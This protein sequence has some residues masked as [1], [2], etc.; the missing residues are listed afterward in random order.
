MRIPA[1]IYSHVPF[2]LNI[3]AIKKGT[4]HMKRNLFFSIRLALIVG[5]GAAVGASA[6]IADQKPDTCSYDP[7]SGNFIENGVESNFGSWE[8][9]RQCAR[10]GRLPE[11]VLNRL[12]AFGEEETRA[13]AAKLKAENRR[14][15]AL[16]RSQQQKKISATE[17]LTRPSQMSRADNQAVGRSHHQSRFSA[18]PQRA[19]IHQTITSNKVGMTSTDPDLDSR[20]AMESGTDDENSTDWIK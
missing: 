9:A 16:R 6:V 11:I 1:F 12:G 14:V 2:C 19:A 3:Q 13:E 4:S 17:D 8:H 5:V 15:A 20:T 7:V 18:P 10:D